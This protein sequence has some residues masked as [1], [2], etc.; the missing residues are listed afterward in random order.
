MLHFIHVVQIEQGDMSF[1]TAIFI[2]IKKKKRKINY[3][4]MQLFRRACEDSESK[5]LQN[6]SNCKS[7]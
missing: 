5:Y 2:L 6:S 4:S 7:F 3:V 1:P